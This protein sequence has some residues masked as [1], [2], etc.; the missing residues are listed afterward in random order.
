MAES[1]HPSSDCA[2]AT[3][4]NLP[5]L[6]VFGPF[7]LIPRQ[8]LLLENGEPVPVGS[9]AL[10]IL[11][12]LIERPGELIAKDALVARA[13]PDTT[14]TADNLRVQIAALRRLLR[15]GSPRHRYIA[16]VPGRGYSFIGAVRTWES[17]DRPEP[18]PETLRSKD[19]VTKTG[20]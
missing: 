10:D 8:R 16:T 14:V 13:W 15:D 17:I 5:E 12:A 1:R 9:R 4:L 6:F 3:S 7:S 18:N 20:V 19:D 11:I 2:S